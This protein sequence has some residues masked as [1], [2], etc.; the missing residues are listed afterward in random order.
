MGAFEDFVNSNLGIRKPLITDTTTPTSSSKAAGIVGTHFLDSSTNFLYEKTGENNS[1]DWV[2]IAYL[3]QPRGGAGGSAGGIESSVQFNSGGFFGG[4]QY[5][6]YNSSAGNLSGISG[7]FDYYSIDFLTGLS[8]YF[9]DEVFVG[10][11]DDDDVLVVE[12]G[13]VNVY[14]SGFFHNPISGG[15]AQFS[16]INLNGGDVE[17]QLKDYAV[18]TGAS[19]DY[20]TQS[21]SLLRDLG[22]GSIDID[23]SPLFS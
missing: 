22:S 13:N 8:G 11:V 3:G 10:G 17:S 20:N 4:D 19:I 7:D 15:A 21:L 14:G 5:L 2:K 9:N 1:T 23:L 12:S 18:V 16:S 6:L